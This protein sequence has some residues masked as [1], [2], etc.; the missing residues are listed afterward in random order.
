M[1]D[2]INVIYF[3]GGYLIGSCLG[4]GAVYM[5]KAWLAARA[6]DKYMRSRNK[7]GK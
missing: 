6:S 4:I 7:G 5:F 1:D 3:L 2:A